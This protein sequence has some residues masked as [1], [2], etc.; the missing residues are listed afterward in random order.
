MVAH[1]SLGGHF[2]YAYFDSN[3]NT[4]NLN[5]NGQNINMPTNTVSAVGLCGSTATMVAPS[6]LGPY[7]WFGPPGTFTNLAA[8][9]VTTNIAGNYTLQM[10]PTGICN[11]PMTRII[12]LSFAPSTALAAIPATVCSG[13]SSTL[14]ASGAT[15]YTWNLGNIVAASTVVNPTSTTIYS[16]TATSGTCIGNYTRQITVNPLPTIVPSSPSGSV[17]GGDDPN[18]NSHRRLNL[19][20]AANEHYRFNRCGCA[21]SQYIIYGRWNRFK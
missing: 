9:T 17:C 20:L 3:C 5:V 6:G 4:M 16:L 15:S 7:R 18:I 12:T 1:C 21:F 19:Y 8:Q 2:G 10:S 14:S 13:S 11:S